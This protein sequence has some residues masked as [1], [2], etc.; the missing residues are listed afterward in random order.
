MKLPPELAELSEFEIV[1]LL[2]AIRTAIKYRA[3]NRFNFFSH[4]SQINTYSFKWSD[5]NHLHLVKM[6]K[7][8]E[9]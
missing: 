3:K 4:E 8:I 7:R 6:E 2:H 5:K 1:E 9:R